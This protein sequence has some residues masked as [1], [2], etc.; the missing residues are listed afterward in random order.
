MS[1]TAFNPKLSVH[2]DANVAGC[3]SIRQW[4]REH[5]VAVNGA[6]MQK[7]Q[8]PEHQPQPLIILAESPT[9]AIVG[10]LVAETQLAWLRI[11][12]MAVA[13]QFRAQGIGS[14][15]LAEAEAQAIRRGCAHAYVDTMEYQAPAFYV[16]HGYTEAGGIADWDSQGHAKYFFTKQLLQYQPES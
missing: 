8:Q 5:N 6:Y 7:L 4:L 2:A 3:E 10:G 16:R 11:S 15:L 13:P 9:G 12:I 1:N 14:A